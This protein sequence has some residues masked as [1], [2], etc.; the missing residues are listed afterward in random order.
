MSFDFDTWKTQQQTK[1]NNRKLEI[2]SA[3]RR[4][5]IVRQARTFW[6]TAGYIA[7]AFGV[8]ADAAFIEPYASDP[9]YLANHLENREYGLGFETVILSKGADN[10]NV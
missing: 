5:L 1:R 3:L 6:S 7:T 8:H 4:G 10:A 9:V 2:E